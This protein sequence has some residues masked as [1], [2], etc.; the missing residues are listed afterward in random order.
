MERLKF[1]TR[2]YILQT[3]LLSLSDYTITYFVWYQY[4]CTDILIMNISCARWC[5]EYFKLGL[6]ST[7]TTL[8]QSPPGNHVAYMRNI[9]L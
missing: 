1:G 3:D 9:H 8:F 2:E 5:N 4:W 6:F 7:I